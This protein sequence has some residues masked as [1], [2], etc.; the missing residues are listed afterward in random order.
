MFLVCQIQMD[1]TTTL[2]SA[3]KEGAEGD[4]QVAAPHSLDQAH[5]DVKEL[6]KGRN[7]PG[8]RRAEHKACGQRMNKNTASSTLVT[9]KD[10]STLP[11]ALALPADSR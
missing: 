10:K 1:L 3:A 5:V 7:Q 2:C 4:V 9:K 8:E 11:D 6:H